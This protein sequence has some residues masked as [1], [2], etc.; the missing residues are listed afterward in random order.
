MSEIKIRPNFVL[1]I[2]KESLTGYLEIVS[3]SL[4]RR[5]FKV[6][7]TR[8]KDYIV[9]PSIGIIQPN[10][11]ITIEVVL[12]QSIK[13]DESHKFA[14][15][16]FEINWRQNTETLKHYLKS[17]QIS[18]LIIHRLGVVY[19]EN[20]KKVPEPVSK[21]INIYVSVGCGFYLCMMICFL[22]GKLFYEIDN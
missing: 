9:K 1:R 17:T 8:P 12:L 15:E 2:N 3:E 5:A 10:E 14:I 6:K 21:D 16:I 4:E 11:E 22:F 18:P 13:I 19:E 20:T 7:T